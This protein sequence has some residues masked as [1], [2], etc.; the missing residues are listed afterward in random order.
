MISPIKRSINMKNK[1]KLSNLNKNKK[2]KNEFGRTGDY[3]KPNRISTSPIIRHVDFEGSR[4]YSFP[5]RT[6]NTITK[7]QIHNKDNKLRMNTQPKNDLRNANSNN[8]F[9]FE[10]SSEIYVKT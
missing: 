3:S 6:I 2:M 1:N 9:G 10:D 8:V 4:L 7:N 5:N